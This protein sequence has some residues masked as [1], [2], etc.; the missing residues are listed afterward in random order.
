MPA[1]PSLGQPHYQVLVPRILNWASLVLPRILL[2]PWPVLPHLYE[3]QLMCGQL[4]W[5]LSQPAHYHGCNREERG[6]KASDHRIFAICVCTNCK[7]LTADCKNKTKNTLCGKA[8][9]HLP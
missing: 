5:V 7:Y 2:L 3:A 8:A 4:I 1:G 9:G 6:E